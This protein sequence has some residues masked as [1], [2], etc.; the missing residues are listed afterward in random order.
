M[1]SP[2]PGTAERSG[3]RQLYQDKE[4]EEKEINLS[5]NNIELSK[6]DSLKNSGLFDSN[7]SVK[8]DMS[9]LKLL[10]SPRTNL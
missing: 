7:I 5:R 6:Q 9:K 8:P 10:K 1:K 4:A 2:E 3:S